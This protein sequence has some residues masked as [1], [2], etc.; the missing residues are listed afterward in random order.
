LYKK[1]TGATDYDLPRELEEDTSIDVGIDASQYRSVIKQLQD[2][3]ISG[4]AKA[5]QLKN[6]VMAGWKN[7]ALTRK[8]INS[9][10]K[11]FDIKL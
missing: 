4:K 10:L 3:E 5:T 2:N 7:G 8:S 9:M 6:R 1:L 11:D